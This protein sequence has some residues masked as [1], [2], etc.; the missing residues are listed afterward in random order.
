[1]CRMGGLSVQKRR[2]QDYQGH[3]L[4]CQFVAL[5]DDTYTFRILA[6]RPFS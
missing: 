3:G 1:M 5:L 6:E 4:E 2:L